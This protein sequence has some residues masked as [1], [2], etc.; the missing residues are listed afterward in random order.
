MFKQLVL[1]LLFTTFGL[2]VQNSTAQRIRFDKKKLD[3]LNQT[4]KVNVVFVYDSLL[5][6]GDI[7]EAAFLKKMEQKIVKHADIP[8]AQQFQ[9]DYKTAKH[10][11][12]P[13]QFVNTI[14]HFSAN[15]KNAP[16]FVVDDPTAIYTMKVNTIWLYFGYDA[17]IVDQPAKATMEIDFYK[18]ETPNTVIESTLISRAMGNY[19][20]QD[21]DGE[22]WPKPNLSKMAKAYDRAGYKFAQA[23]RRV[24]D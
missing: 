11:D 1:V 2:G 12:W 4:E 14:N 7:P 16:T 6:N 21:G 19:N 18:T 24:V 5:F 15:Y 8:M 9:L 22:A 20:N 17:G 10:V 3:F 13:K 23:I